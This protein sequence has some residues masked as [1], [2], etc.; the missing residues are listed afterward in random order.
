MISI[1]I[2][3]RKPDISEEFK[4]NIRETIGLEYELIIVD[5]TLHHK[6]IF[7][8]YNY[9][10][11]RAKYRTLCFIHD[12]IL[13]HTL[14]WGEVILEHLKKPTVGFI[15]VAGGALIPRVPTQWS[16]D[17]HF[18]FLLQYDKGKKISKMEEYGNFNSMH[19][20]PVVAVDGV[21]LA[22]RKEL[23][24]SIRFDELTF[25][26]FHCY[27]LDICLQ[28]HLLGY[29]N[30]V[31]NNILLE[32]FSKGK[33]NKSWVENQLINWRKWRSKL[34]ADLTQMAKE[35]LLNKEIY[36]L[37]NSFTRRM[38]RRGFSNKE[39]REVFKEYNNLI[40]PEGTA[41]ASMNNLRITWIRL[42]KRPLSLLKKGL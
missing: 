22:C 33:L 9:G 32:H 12:D 10:V 30:R 38:I 21:F 36:Y 41:Y 7:T 39:I 23:F 40:K 16:F 24:D 2:C 4:N 18:K 15:G 20:Q 34:P 29:E 8:A 26:G 19:F 28:A 14:N 35:E 31:I 13:F 11:D 3:S 37:E 1:I 5:E 17:R 6:S 42:T 25:K 27:D